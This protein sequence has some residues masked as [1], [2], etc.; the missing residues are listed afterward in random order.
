MS[1]VDSEPKS[2]S[3]PPKSN[4]FLRGLADE[5][6]H[7]LLDKTALA[8]CLAVNIRTLDE[9]V[10][11]GEVPPPIQVSGP[12]WMPCRVIAWFERMAEEAEAAQVIELR[13]VN[14]LKGGHNLGGAA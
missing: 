9:M 1:R 7:A 3:R 14:A 10:R 12:R 2:R 13:R 5:P 4:L 8:G 11:R 6:P